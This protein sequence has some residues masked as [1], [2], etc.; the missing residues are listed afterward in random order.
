[1]NHVSCT[2][3][4]N[5]NVAVLMSVVYVHILGK[6]RQNMAEFLECFALNSKV[7]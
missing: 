1:M 3:L 5:D 7:N 2:I 6:E 4:R